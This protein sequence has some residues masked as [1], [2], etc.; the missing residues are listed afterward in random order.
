MREQKY[1]C[2]AK[3]SG[4]Q[5]LSSSKENYTRLIVGTCSWYYAQNISEKRDCPKGSVRKRENPPKN[6]IRRTF[7]RYPCW[8]LKTS[9]CGLNYTISY[10][11]DILSYSRPT[12][13][14]DFS[15]VLNFHEE[16]L[17]GFFYELYCCIVIW[18]CCDQLIIAR[19][20]EKS[21][22]Y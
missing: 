15:M 18:K 1:V 19:S 13:I 11:V 5:S 3:M 2:K 21:Y 16:F 8:L 9:Y 7:S 20:R 10:S 12:A 4:S 14:S 17:D 22:R 6:C